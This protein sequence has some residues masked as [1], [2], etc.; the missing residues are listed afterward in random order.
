MTFNKLTCQDEWAEFTKGSDKQLVRKKDFNFMQKKDT[1][2]FPNLADEDLWANRGLFNPLNAELNPT[3]HL[4][5]LV[6]VTIFST[7]AG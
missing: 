1:E 4:L 2:N 5:A 6:E 3:C 7:L